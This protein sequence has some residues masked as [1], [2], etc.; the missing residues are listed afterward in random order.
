[1]S[2][3]P[4][5]VRT[6]TVTLRLLEER[7]AEIERIVSED[8]QGILYRRV[9][10]FTPTQ[11]AQMNDLIRAMRQQIRRATNAFELPR[12]EQ[13]AARH[14][15]GALSMSWESLEEI[16]PRKLKSY[17]EV[18]PELKQTLDPI[19]QRLIRLLFRLEDVAGDKTLTES[20]NF[21]EE[22]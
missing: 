5:Q 18:D 6:V 21:D 12:E 20:T 15:I 17:G 1:M 7:L 13:N 2:L 4:N 16:R 9:A 8:E 14:I 10:R 22:V 11:R 19:L 3:N